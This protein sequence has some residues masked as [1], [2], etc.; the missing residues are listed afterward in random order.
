MTMA[1]MK[2]QAAIKKVLDAA[3]EPVHYTDIA[4]AIIDEGL[5][6]S[7]GA[8]PA[9]TVA[10]QLSRP[11]LV[12]EVVRVERGTYALANRHSA[13]PDSEV[14]VDIL[15]DIAPV[16]PS[17]STDLEDMGLINAFGMY[18]RRDGI[19]W[20]RN[21]AAQLFGSQQSGSERVDFAPQA[22]IYLLH[23]R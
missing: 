16:A 2:W 17:E 14:L 6:T 12:H 20:S 21:R 18:W 23:D 22:G 8:T 3:E 4:Q 11:P 19:D 5:R 7:V 15:D 1:Q 13:A 9:A 10:A